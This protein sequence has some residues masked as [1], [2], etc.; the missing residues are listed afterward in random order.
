MCQDLRTFQ[1]YLDDIASIN[2]FPVKNRP[3]HKYLCWEFFH[4]VSDLF[5]KRGLRMSKVISDSHRW[6]FVPNNFDKTRSHC[7]FGAL[8]SINFKEVV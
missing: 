8:Y 2:S 5:Q 3:A 7:Y 4:D 1:V 6:G